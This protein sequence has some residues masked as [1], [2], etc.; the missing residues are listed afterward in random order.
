MADSLSMIGIARS[1]TLPL[2]DREREV[3]Q[4][5]YDLAV[6]AANKIRRSHKAIPGR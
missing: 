4:L 5:I 1:P 3:Q 6:L 2:Q